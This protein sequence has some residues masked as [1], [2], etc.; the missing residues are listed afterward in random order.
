MSGCWLSDCFGNDFRGAWGGIRPGRAHKPHTPRASAQ[1]YIQGEL[2]KG[3]V[4]DDM[5]EKKC[6]SNGWM[7]I[8]EL[9]VD[10]PVGGCLKQNTVFRR[11]KR[12]RK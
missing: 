12:E 3:I 10:V 6:L 5:R 1:K 8:W 11:Q 9:G 2:D 7:G 4:S